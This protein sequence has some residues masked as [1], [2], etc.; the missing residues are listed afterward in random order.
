MKRRVIVIGPLPPP[1]HGVTVSTSLVLANPLLRDRFEVEHLDTSDP[2]TLANVGSWDLENVRV[3]AKSVARLA[4]M[5]HKPRGVVY[6]PLSQSTPAFL[7]DSLFVGAASAR[8]WKVAAHLRGSDFR[9]FYESS[10]LAIRGLIRATLRRVDSVAVMGPSLR[11]LFEGLVPSD[12]I[13]VVANGT[14]EPNLNGVSRDLDTVLFL[15][16]LRPRKGVAEAVAAARLV[17]DEHPSARFL[18]VGDWADAEFERSIRT[19]AALAGDRIQFRSALT[20][21]AKDRLLAAASIFLF[22]PAEPEG[23]PRVVLEALAAGLPVVTTN[24]GAIADT[25]VDGESG[26]VL[27]E[28]SPPELASRL[29]QLLRDQALRERMSHAARTQYLERFTQDHADQAL[30]DWLKRLA[31]S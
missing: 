16:N 9:A 7:R 15:S 11:W 10:P 3:G 12:R 24:R 6:L 26:F 22:P 27:A 8:G 4:A 21:G 5:L 25:V 30:V 29:L 31:E 19:E 17:L 1:H 2:R 28:P 20:D 23:H 13:A 18:F 14:P